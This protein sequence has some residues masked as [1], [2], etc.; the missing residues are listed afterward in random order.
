VNRV[1]KRRHQKKKDKEFMKRENEATEFH[2]GE[3]YRNF[4]VTEQL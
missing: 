4:I 1:E 2:R 3:K